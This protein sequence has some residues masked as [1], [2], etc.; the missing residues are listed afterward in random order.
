M[1]FDSPFRALGI[2]AV[3]CFAI[4]IRLGV[5]FQVDGNAKE[6]SPEPADLLALDLIQADH[7]FAKQTMNL[8]D[9]NDD[10]HL[11]AVELR[12]LK[13]KIEPTKFDVNMD[14]RLTKLEIAMHFAY[15]RKIHGI[16]QFDLNNARLF[17]RRYDK[18][19]DRELSAY[20]IREGGWPPEPERFD[21]NKDGIITQA[22]LAVGF[23]NKRQTRIERGVLNIDM[24]NAVRFLRRY[25]ANGDRQIDPTE[26]DEENSMIKPAL[27]DE[28][29]NGRLINSEIA[30]GF[31]QIRK[32]RGVTAD[33]QRQAQ[34]QLRLRDRNGD[35]QLDAEEIEAAKWPE[36]PNRYDL[37][38]DEKLTAA[39]VAAYFARERGERGVT[40]EDQLAA[41]RL[42]S[43][44]DRNGN[45]QI[46]LFEVESP[47]SE[48]PA[49]K[50][51]DK[52]VKITPL[53]FIEYDRDVDQRLSPREVAAMLAQQ[54]KSDK[55]K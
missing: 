6:D 44:H 18:N 26:F 19:N 30:A 39:E 35:D 4:F 16:T 31:A 13:W 15:D 42:I 17:L 1:V 14:G 53:T 12:K 2:S 43:R 50:T 20:E 48:S 41:T 24:A 38:G 27:F 5:G 11:D 36:N 33:D 34:T 55:K 46:D 23:A 8:C 9:K 3:C 51:E 37:D 22:E 54:R 25:D 7:N 47:K 32:E 28:D 40:P 10:S 49:D 52:A 29:K 45:R 21:A